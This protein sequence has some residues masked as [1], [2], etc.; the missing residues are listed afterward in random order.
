MNHKVKIFYPIK[1]DEDGNLNLER[2]LNNWLKEQKSTIQ[3]HKMYL[4][5]H[6]QTFFVWYS[7]S[8]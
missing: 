6:P 1:L 7:E 3:I 2:N 4:T 8:E 5:G